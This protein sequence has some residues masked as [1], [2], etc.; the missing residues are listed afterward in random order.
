MACLSATNNTA[1]G[2]DNISYEILR[3]LPQESLT[4]LLNV[5]NKVWTTQSFPDSWRLATVI[6]IPKPGK[7]HTDASNYRPISLTS[8]LCKLMEK[9]VNRRLVWFLEHTKSLSDLQCGFRKNRTTVDH[10]VRLESFIRE[11]FVK[12]EHMVAIFFDLEKAFDTTWKFGILKDLHNLGLRGHLPLFIREFL[13]DRSFQV[14]VG[15]AISDPQN[16]EEGV[17]QGSILSPI[18]FEIKINS[19]VNTLRQNVDCSLYVDDFLVCYRSKCKMHII[20]RQLQLQLDRLKVWADLNGFTFSPSKTFAVHFCLKHSC[21]RDPDLYI[22]NK[23]LEVRVQARFL[24]V[25][26]DRKLNFLPHVKDLRIR[27]MKALRA[28]KVLANPVWGAD[29]TILLQLYRTLVRSKLDYAS[30]IYGSA[31]KYVIERLDPVHHQGLRL[32]LGAFRTS[33]VQSL[34]AEADEPSLQLR[35]RKLA[36]QYTSKLQTLTDNPAHS[37]V[38]QISRQ[39]KQIFLAHPKTIPPIGI[40]IQ[41]DTANMNLN[42]NLQVV[43]TTPQTAPW[44]IKRPNIDLRL[45]T[46]DKQSTDPQT[47]KQTLQALLETYADHTLVYT[48]GSKTDDA[49]ACAFYSIEGTKSCRLDNRASIFTAEST[50]L[51]MACDFASKAKN[52]KV[53]FLSDSLS[54]LKALKRHDNHDKRILKISEKVNKLFLKGRTVSFLWVPSHVG[55]QGNEKADRLAKEALLLDLPR[56]CAVPHSDL[57]PHINKMIR[58]EWREV[59]ARETNNKLHELKPVL[60]PRP[61]KR[62]RRAEEVSLTR[63]RIGHTRLT[64]CYILMGEAEPRCETCNC[65][66]TVRHILIECPSLRPVRDKYFSCRDMRELFGS[67]RRDRDILDFLREIDYLKKL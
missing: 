8:C 44:L 6:P 60:G 43:N 20:E 17:P 49:V 65:S 66:L 56:G 62:L 14:K 3:H 37:E 51:E 61:T 52:K 26:F 47:Y 50:A 57:K 59:W 42:T 15:S 58:D 5:F 67:G 9:M 25:I 1:P 55:I 23:K 46:L 54:C 21:V 27:C 34:L 28:L 35:R 12:G 45:A 13:K 39:T 53:G 38:H 30:F 48:D 24:G 22:N 19:I 2:P 29:S 41:Q 36:L 11:A 32:A 7:D 63:L 64:H 4:V 33:P 16:Q 31:R 40:R 18:L 10:L